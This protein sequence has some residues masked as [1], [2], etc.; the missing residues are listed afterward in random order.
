MIAAQGGIFGWVTSAQKYI[1]A[2]GPATVG[3]ALAQRKG[4]IT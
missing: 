3:A 1:D 4:L 2:L